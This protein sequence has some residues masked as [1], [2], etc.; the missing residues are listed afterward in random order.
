MDEYDSAGL[1]MMLDA[2][3]APQPKEVAEKRFRVIQ[4]VHN[5]NKKAQSLQIAAAS[6]VMAHLK[7]LGFATVRPSACVER[8]AN[9]QWHAG[10]VLRTNPLCGMQLGPRCGRGILV[11]Y[12]APR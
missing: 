7:A 8:K 12:T 9:S 11:R 3:G 2:M 6:P 5:L 1:G 4:L 10:E